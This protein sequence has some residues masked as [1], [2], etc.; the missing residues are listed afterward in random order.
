MKVVVTGGAGKI[1]AYVVRELSA[2]H[3]VTVFDRLPPADSK[4]TRWIR[5]DIESFDEVLQALAGA[6]AVVHL[7]GIPIPG[8]VPDH[9]LFRINTLGTYNVHEACYRLGIKRIVSTSSGAVLGWTYGERELIPE[10]LP[11]DEDHPVNPHDPYGMSKL[12]G[13]EIARAYALKCGMEAIA[14]R[15]PRVLFPEGARQLR[16]QGGGQPKRRFDLCAY[17]DPRDLAQ[18]YRRAVETPD[19][20]HTV[21]FIA[22]DDSTAAEP[23]CKLLPRLMPALG[24]KAR[25]L[26]GDRPGVSNDRAKRLLQWQPRYSWRRGE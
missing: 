20:K 14:L 23:L 6:D 13:E 8:K 15:P 7:A 19:L 11:I 1:G 2:G 5:G 22:A 17:I 18:A 26:T 16:E 10:Y 4:E 9:V 12:C 25:N 21:F 3:T 24:E